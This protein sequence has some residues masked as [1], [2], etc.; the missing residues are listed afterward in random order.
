M[1]ALG[2]EKVTNAQKKAIAAKLF[3]GGEYN[4][5][6]LANLLD[7]SEKTIGT[8]KEAGNWEE[9]R[10]ANTVSGDEIIRGLIADTKLILEKAQREGRAKDSKETDAVMKNAKAIQVL[11]SGV[12]VETAIQ[13]FKRFNRWLVEADPT[14]ASQF[15]EL[16]P[17]FLYTLSAQD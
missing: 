11:R 8:W 3:I 2:M 6:E 10:D 13:V 12:S 14:L 7:V 16:M 1:G 15:T 17:R 4:Q 9:L 5:K